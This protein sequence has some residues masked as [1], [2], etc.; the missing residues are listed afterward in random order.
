M[1]TFYELLRWA[2]Y[3]L[4]ITMYYVSTINPNDFWALI[5]SCPTTTLATLL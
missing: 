3:V 5:A 4:M 2:T 1:I